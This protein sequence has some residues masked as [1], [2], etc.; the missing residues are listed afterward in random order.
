MGLFNAEYEIRIGAAAAAREREE[1]AKIAEAVKGI[2]G[3]AI[4]AKIRERGTP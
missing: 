1:C 3:A 2:V 4:A